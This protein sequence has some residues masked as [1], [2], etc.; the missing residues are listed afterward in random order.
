[1]NS[2][3]PGCLNL[4]VVYRLSFEETKTHFCSCSVQIVEACGTDCSWCET[5][6][7]A[8]RMDTGVRTKALHQGSLQKSCFSSQNGH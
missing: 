2:Q 8:E 7:H 4:H 6:N 5:F 3:P 1:M